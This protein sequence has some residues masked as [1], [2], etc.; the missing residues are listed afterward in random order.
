MVLAAM[1]APQPTESDLQTYQMSGFARSLQRSPAACKVTRMD[2]TEVFQQIVQLGR[3][4]GALPPDEALRVLVTMIDRLDVNSECFEL[5]VAAMMRVGA[6]IWASTYG[7]R[8][9]EE[10]E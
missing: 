5:D 2:Q 7:M 10:S 3:A 9:A 6:T 1:H 8:I 4:G